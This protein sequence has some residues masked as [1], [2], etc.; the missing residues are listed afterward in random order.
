M[1]KDDMGFNFN[2][3]QHGY[4]YFYIL[5]LPHLLLQLSGFTFKIPTK[6]HPDGSR[7]WPQYRYEALAFFARCMVLLFLAWHRKMMHFNNYTH[8]R[9]TEEV[10]NDIDAD[11]VKEKGQDFISSPFV[12]YTIV[13]CTMLAADATS[14]KFKAIGQSSRTLRDLD[15]SQGAIL[16]MSAAQFHATLHSLL[17]NDRPCVQIAALSVVQLS[18]FG[19]T[20]R[21]KGIISQ[22]QGLVLYG[23]VLIVGM[24][25]IVDDLYSHGMLGFA[26]AMGNLAA[27]VRFEWNMNKYWLWS[28]MA[29][30]L[31][32]CVIKSDDG[33]DVGRWIGIWSGKSSTCIYESEYWIGLSFASTLG[34]L[35]V[36]A[37]RELSSQQ[38]CKDS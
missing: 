1:L 19:M 22:S 29:L 9:R 2:A 7:I 34:L 5:F 18:A 27:I 23:L 37:K 3:S 10:N 25:V 15:G 11:I 13:I 12:A 35:Y 4:F 31:Q 33:M 17:T 30:I 32:C 14:H 21:R 20:L 24:I 38:Y 28:I 6:R 26:I 36:A 16:L 8:H